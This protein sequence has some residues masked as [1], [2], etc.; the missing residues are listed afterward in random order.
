MNLEV[1]NQFFQFGDIIII[2]DSDDY[3]VGDIITYNNNNDYLI[4]HRIISKEGALFETKGDNN[5][6]KDRNIV[7]KDKIEGKVICN[8]KLL[9]FIY[10]NWLI[11]MIVV[12]FLLILL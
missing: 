1:W 2:K 11:V 6:T 7:S 9:R 10:E 12:L 8:S 4:T 5:N 3:E